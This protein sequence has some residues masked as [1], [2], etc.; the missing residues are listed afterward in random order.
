MKNDITMLWAEMRTIGCTDTI[1][2][3]LLHEDQRVRLN[4][5]GMCMK[6]NN[7]LKNEAKVVLRS[8]IESQTTDRT[9][10]LEAKIYLEEDNPDSIFYQGDCVEG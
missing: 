8:L 2:R 9:I 4:A 6:Y 5:A 3:L 7:I 10:H 1:G